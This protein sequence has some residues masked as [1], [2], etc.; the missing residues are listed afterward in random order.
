ML[1]TGNRVAD[2]HR[3][4]PGDSADVAGLHLQS[5]CFRQ[6]AEGIELN[7]FLHG[8]P[9]LTVDDGNG[10]CLS[11]FAGKNPPHRNASEIVGIVNGC[12]EHL[13]RG[14]NIDRRRRNLLDNRFKNRQHILTRLLEVR[15]SPAVFG[16]GIKNGKIERIIVG[17]KGNKQIEDLIKDIVRTCVRTVHLVNYHDGLKF[18]GQG[19]G[20][21]KSR[22]R[23][24]PIESVH[25]QQHSISHFQHT[26][27][28]SAEVGMAGRIHDVDFELLTIRGCVFDSAVFA[29]DG[30]ASLP[31]KRVRVHNQAVSSAGQLLQL[32]F[33]EHSGLAEQL[34]HQR[35][36]AM[37]HMGNNSDISYLFRHPHIYL[38]SFQIGLKKGAV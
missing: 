28:L 12:H 36:L 16:R 1:I 5:R 38:I 30:N 14:M 13:Q 11:C 25:Q 34:V 7:N 18:A 29:E 17:V 20:E 33:A 32:A 15:Y 9:P 4:Q 26:L 27:H 3:R 37:V 35:G 23:H 31:L 21:N 24:R 6:S 2:V 22:L 8:M 19:L 10:I